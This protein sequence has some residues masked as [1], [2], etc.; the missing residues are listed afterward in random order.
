MPPPP[1]LGRWWRRSCGGRRRSGRRSSRRAGSPGTTAPT[2][3][4]PPA[5]ALAGGLLLTGV[6]LGRAV[7]GHPRGRGSL[8]PLRSAFGGRRRRSSAPGAVPATT[9]GL[10]LGHLDRD[11]V[12][13]R[14]GRHAVVR[15]QLA[16]DRVEG[17]AVGRR[18][19]SRGPLLRQGAH[20][21]LGRLGRGGLTLTPS[22]APAAVSRAPRRGRA[23]GVELARLLPYLPP[24]GAG[25]LAL[26][27]FPAPT[28]PPPRLAH[29]PPSTRRRRG[30]RARP[31]TT[32]RGRST[33]GR[34][35]G[36]RAR[37]S[38]RSRAGPSG[39]RARLRGGTA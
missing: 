24:F 23:R 19:Q 32:S 10:L 5:P 27:R 25:L 7:G 21:V 16:N 22:L 29:R 36:R 9:G 33:R 3:A 1:L 15:L 26:C 34:R 30:R 2:T 6:L 13:L 35:C 28:S 37:R 11:P 14:V 17:L 18:R 38:R 12:L 8:L 31:T 39:P 4:S 20:Q